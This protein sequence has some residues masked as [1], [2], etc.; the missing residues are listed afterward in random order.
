MSMPLFIALFTVV[1]YMTIAYPLARLGTWSGA[2]DFKTSLVLALVI[3]AAMFAVRFYNE[4]AMSDLS[5]SAS[6]TLYSLWGWFGV[7]FAMVLVA[8]IARIVFL[9]A[10]QPGAYNLP[11]LDLRLGIGLVAA[12][13]AVWGYGTWQCLRAPFINHIEIASSKVSRSYTFIHISD[14]QLGS[15]SPDYA[16]SVRKVMNDIRSEHKVDAVLHTGDVVDTRAYTKEQLSALDF[17]KLPH[18]FSLGNHEFYHDTPRLLPLLEDL[19]HTLLRE[20]SALLEEI[21]IIGIDDADKPEQV[22]EKL[23]AAPELVREDKFN[24]LLYHRPTGVD[25]AAQRGIDLMLCGHTHGGQMLPYAW[26]VRSMYK[27]AQGS[28][29]VGDMLLHTT[30][31]LGLWG[32]RVRIGTRNE[33]AV[34]KI[35][36]N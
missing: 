1:L 16:R 2:L 9:L 32:P 26:L 28:T 8:E 4:S 21:N 27:Y 18:Y 22:A 14:L 25:D 11:Q 12:I 31:G 29:Q 20:S 10:A 13:T 5:S 23:D 3:V 7:A 34:I 19:N 15:M 17:G 24:I 6:R 33:L 35:V 36:P 30:D